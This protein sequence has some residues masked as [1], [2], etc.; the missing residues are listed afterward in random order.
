MGMEMPIL[1][2]KVNPNQSMK[3]TSLP[4][5]LFW[6]MASP[7]YIQAQ[8]MNDHLI[9][10]QNRVTF[11]INAPNAKE[12][13]IINL[14]DPKA[15]GAAAYDLT[16]GENGI[17]SATTLPC[18]PGFHYYSL[19]IDGFE[20]SDP[21]SQM[22]FGWGKWSSGLEVPDPDIDFYLPQDHPKGEVTTHWY[23]SHVTG[24]T[25]KCLVY[26]PLGYR[27]DTDQKYPV[28]YLQH[29]S[30]ESELGWTMQGKV[31]FILDNLI[32]SGKAKPM[33]IVM[34]NGYAA[35]PDATN[36]SRPTG[37]ENKFE[38]ILLND[39]IPEIDSHYRT[40]DSRDFRAL[41]G[42]SIGAGQAQRIGFKNLETF[43]S[44]GA[45]S[46]GSGNFDIN[47]TSSGV[48]I[49]PTQFN[50]RVKLYW[51]GCGYLDRAFE[52]AKKM[53]QSL[54]AQGIKHIWYEMNGSHEWQV[55]RKHLFEFAQVVFQ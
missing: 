29:G 27:V 10:E 26:T 2:S 8:I 1:H 19:L 30:G 44:I 43:S 37:D 17:W 48:F 47:S 9:D 51:I 38:E 6:A 46:G 28:L 52:G 13:K 7:S 41:A 4:F 3:K 34:D 11:T 32:A 42:L 36:P 49:N 33:I 24:K 16:K 21:K 14:S 12:V 15:M 39:L 25:R 31:N 18:R 50:E 53:H 22:Y 5:L 40:L 23:T 55:W 45:F 20:T 35:S 54:E